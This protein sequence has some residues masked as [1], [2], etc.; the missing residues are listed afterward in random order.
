MT[1]HE[2]MLKKLLSFFDFVLYIL[3]RRLRPKE[4][5]DKKYKIIE[6]ITKSEIFNSGK[7]DD[8]FVK[9]FQNYIIKG[10]Y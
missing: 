4:I 3:N 8:Q 7:I 2:I 5:C 1:T 10:P 9:Q 6:N